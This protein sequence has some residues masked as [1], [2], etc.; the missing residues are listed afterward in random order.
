MTKIII[1]LYLLDTNQQWHQNIK[2]NRKFTIQVK[3]W[4]EHDVN[5]NIAT[6]RHGTN[7]RNRRAVRS[8]TPL[9]LN[10]NSALHDVDAK[11]G[12]S[13][14]QLGQVINRGVI[15]GNH[16]LYVLGSCYC[17]G[18]LK[19]FTIILSAWFLW[20]SLFMYCEYSSENIFRLNFFVLLGRYLILCF[21]N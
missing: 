18:F 1:G 4:T 7:K 9:R 19:P 6:S 3:F 10:L 15:K 5:N 14:L 17:S 12:I 2:Y 20:I 21:L 11:F 13:N 16:T 8:G